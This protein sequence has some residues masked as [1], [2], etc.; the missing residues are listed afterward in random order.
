MTDPLDNIQ[1]YLTTQGYQNVFIDGFVV[2]PGEDENN[3]NQVNIQSEPSST[4][5]EVG[6]REVDWGIY[7]KNRDKETAKNTA[8]AI[9]T[10]LLNKCGKLVAG[11]NS[12]VFKKIWVSTEPYFWSLTQNNENIYLARYK[13]IISDTDIKTVYDD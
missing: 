11:L 8:K 2:F 10:L 6:F 9:R 13:A 3:Y 1:T 4:D 7:V 12:V 5:I